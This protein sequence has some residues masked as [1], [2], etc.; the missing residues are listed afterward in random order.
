MFL[1]EESLSVFSK[2]CVHTLGDNVM[3]VL[4]VVE[5]ERQGDNMTPSWRDPRRMSN[6]NKIYLEVMLDPTFFLFL[7]LVWSFFLFFNIFP[8]SFARVP[9][10]VL[11]D[12][13]CYQAKLSS[14]G[15][16]LCRFYFYF[17]FY[18]FGIFY[19]VCVVEVI[20]WLCLPRQGYCV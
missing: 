15:Y 6:C 18:F 9:P 1:C 4:G 12:N 13:F 10:Q 11:G 2:V 8:L 3:L 19:V 5:V 14:M 20:Y 17:Y 7:L 16:S